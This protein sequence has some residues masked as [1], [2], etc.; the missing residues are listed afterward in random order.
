[1]TQHFHA[2]YFNP[3]GGRYLHTDATRLAVNVALATRRPL[4]VRGRPGSGKS[5]LAVEVAA[6][7][8]WRYLAQV[9]TSRV[10]AQDLLWRFDAVRRFSDAQLRDQ[11]LPPRAAYVLPQVLWQAFDPASAATFPQ[12][13]NQPAAAPPA[14]GPC[15][16]LIDEIDKA[17]PD[18]P[19]DLLEVLEFAR[20]QVDDLDVPLTV[21]GNRDEILIIIASNDERDM[22]AAFLRRCTVLELPAPQPGWLEQVAAVH[23][24]PDTDGLYAAVARLTAAAAH[25]ARQNGLREPGTAE[26]LDAV[27]ACR[28]LQVRPDPQDPTWQLLETLVLRKA[29]APGHD[30]PR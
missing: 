13:A 29:G 17:E 1:M 27:R 12:R 21:Q 4:F 23:H 5:S 6:Q 20:F 24:G 11:D 9:V 25:S 2:K 14:T 30:L 7:L 28:E 16:V 18:V 19:N 26:Y 10:R 22:P 8:G 3:A 15:V